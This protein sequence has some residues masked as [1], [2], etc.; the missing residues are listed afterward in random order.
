MIE[1]TG[2]RVLERIDVYG[3][4]LVATLAPWRCATCWIL[5][6]A[7]PGDKAHDVAELE[8]TFSRYL[9]ERARIHLDEGHLVW[10]GAMPPFS[11]TTVAQFL[12]GRSGDPHL[13]EAR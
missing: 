9:L 13:D 6:L 1:S 7:W 2:A 12:I 3:E 10:G 8:S 5:R 4:I 11:G